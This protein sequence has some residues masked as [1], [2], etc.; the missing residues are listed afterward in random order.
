[1]AAVSAFTV[2][3]LLAKR[4]PCPLH[5]GVAKIPDSLSLGL[6]PS[7]IGDRK[8][9][10]IIFCYTLI[11]RNV[12]KPDGCCIFLV[13]AAASFKTSLILLCTTCSMYPLSFAI[14]STIAP[15]TGIP[16][17]LKPIIEIPLKPIIS[18]A[19]N[20]ALTG[21]KCHMKVWTEDC[22]DGRKV[23]TIAMNVISAKLPAICF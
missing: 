7:G 1:M 6:K 3:Y 18:I 10:S 17:I 11:S 20:I 13:L 15:L 14:D 4:L 9:E 8:D 22:S 19:S 5:T 2:G 12:L 16:Q 23:V 21:K